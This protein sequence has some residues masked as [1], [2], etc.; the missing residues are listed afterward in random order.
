MRTS[1][2][3]SQ[4]KYFLAG[5]VREDTY[6]NVVVEDMTKRFWRIPG[7]SPVRYHRFE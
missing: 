4:G 1:V 7:R 2:Y 5:F 6:L 3:S